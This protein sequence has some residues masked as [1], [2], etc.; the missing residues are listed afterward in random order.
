MVHIFRTQSVFSNFEHYL[1][2]INLLFPN[3]NQADSDKTFRYKLKIKKINYF[4]KYFLYIYV[5][6][7]KFR[8][9]ELSLHINLGQIY[10]IIIFHMIWNI[11]KKV[12]FQQSRFISWF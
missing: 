3:Q 9:K 6:I 8:L 2:I 7:K 1:E 4:I 5:Y 12:F 11:F 10:E